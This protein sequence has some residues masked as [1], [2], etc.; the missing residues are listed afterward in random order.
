MYNILH[1][2]LSS[3]NPIHFISIYGNERRSP[4]LFPLTQVHGGTYTYE[5][6]A[7]LHSSCRSI[8]YCHIFARCRGNVARC[9]AGFNLDYNT[10][11]SSGVKFTAKLL[12]SSLIDVL[13][14]KEEE[15]TISN[16]YVT[17]LFVGS[18]V[19]LRQEAL[20][21]VKEMDMKSL[22]NLSAYRQQGLVE[23]ESLYIITNCSGVWPFLE[24]PYLVA[25][26][27]KKRWVS[28]NDSTE[29]LEF[30]RFVT[31]SLYCRDSG[32]ESQLLDITGLISHICPLLTNGAFREEPWL[33]LL[34]P[35]STYSGT[36]LTK[37]L[38]AY[39]LLLRA[40]QTRYR[41]DM[42]ERVYANTKPAMVTYTDGLVLPCLLD[43]KTDQIV[44][45]KQVLP[46]QQVGKPVL[47]SY[48]DMDDT[49]IFRRCIGSTTTSLE[50]TD[51]NKSLVERLPLPTSHSFIDYECDS[52]LYENR[53]C[54]PCNMID[55]SEAAQKHRLVSSNRATDL[56]FYT[57]T[58]C[59]NLHP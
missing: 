5:V 40:F 14:S 55:D 27:A 18:S 49:P 16:V 47:L 43:S 35:D 51:C 52:N 58:T 4:I 12:N 39:E 29:F 56:I 20:T 59:N 45:V 10:L 36:S 54:C 33:D 41:N 8:I 32:R 25:W 26:R 48:V 2:R 37:T 31:Q 21:K 1:L 15:E 7:R 13:S 28:V 3:H 34:N 57:L 9:I 44:S 17:I 50:V 30:C 6:E 23:P 22:V 53:L 11:M 38:F 42:F 46:Q 19:H 24:L